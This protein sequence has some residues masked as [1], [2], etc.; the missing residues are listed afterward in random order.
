MNM[1]ATLAEDE[2]FYAEKDLDLLMD[3]RSKVWGGSHLHTDRGFLA[4]LF[5]GSPAGEPAGIMVRHRGRAV[6]FAGLCR[7]R[8]FV[9]GREV[10]LAHGLDYMVEPGL[11]D[12]L[13]GR[14]ALRVPQRWHLLATTLGCSSSVVFPNR[15]S[16]RML[17][18][19]RVGMLPIFKPDLLIRPLPSARFTS[20]ARGI[21]APVL[22]AGVRLAS[23]GSWICTRSRGRARGELVSIDRFDEGFDELWLG[24]RSVLGTSTVRNAAYLNWRFLANPTYRYLRLGWRCD[25]GWAGYAVCVE[26]R[27]FGIDTLLLVD[28]LSP[29]LASVGAA[30]VDAVVAEACRRK[31]GMVM[32]LAIRNS[33]LHQ[34]V[35]SLGFIAVPARLNPKPFTA[36][37]CVYDDLVRAELASEPRNFTWSDMDVV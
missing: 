3:L 9:A 22:S 27:V 14:V 15:H 12:V 25:S 29:Q 18:S 19:P 21:P 36:T 4:W 23:V 13:A 16:M 31:L 26:R 8:Q 6:G 33:A 17:T 34:V 7:K 10:T 35:D 28:L 32:T 20:G 11:S 2:L 1:P 24:T 30:L 5:A 37:E